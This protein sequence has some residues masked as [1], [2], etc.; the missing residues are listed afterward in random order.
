LANIIIYS[1]GSSRGN[2]GRGGF[3]AILISGNHR[4]EISGG[5]H[6]TTNNRM[7]LLAV[8]AALECLKTHSNDI[9]IYSDSQYVVN[10]I[11]KGWLFKW[12]KNKKEFTNSD[13]WFRLLNIYHLNK[14]KFKW[15]KGHAD[16]LENNRCDFLATQAAQ[17]TNL[18][19]DLGYK[20]RFK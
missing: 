14:I 18:Q 15:I 4:K 11:E 1:D 10:S 9:T 20:L 12:V 16:N 2:P 7:E 19:E 13:L 8:V 3:G 17:S 6:L 5:F